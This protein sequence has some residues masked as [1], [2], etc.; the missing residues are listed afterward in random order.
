MWQEQRQERR[1]VGL[2]GFL[3]NRPRLG[4]RLELSSFPWSAA[5]TPDQAAQ[6]KKLWER[7]FPDSEALLSSSQRV[8]CA[9]LPGQPA[10]PPR[11]VRALCRR[12][13]ICLQE[14]G[15]IV[16]NLTQ[17]QKT[18]RNLGLSEHRHPVILEQLGTLLQLPSTS[19]HTKRDSATKANLVC[20]EP[21]IWNLLALL[22]LCVLQVCQMKE[23]R[24]KPCHF[25]GLEVTF[26]MIALH[27]TQF[28]ST[29]SHILYPC[30]LHIS[31]SAD[32]PY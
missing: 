25:W 4:S 32:M 22:H 21:P 14:A 30:I 29:K 13:P 2:P 15:G 17:S 19:E 31:Y 12:S 3:R 1:V 18:G 23:E 10:A 11:D 5:K 20:P 7:S 8:S 16:I 27:R 6:V 26:L 24:Q 9:R 28:N